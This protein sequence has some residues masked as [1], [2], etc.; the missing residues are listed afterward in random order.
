ML[1]RRRRGLEG[2]GRWR[3]RGG[4]RCGCRRGGFGLG[5]GT[6]WDGVPEGRWGFRCG[7]G[8]VRG[9]YFNDG[10]FALDRREWIGNGCRILSCVQDRKLRP[11]RCAAPMLSASPS[12]IACCCAECGV[13]PSTQMRSRELSLLV[14]HPRTTSLLKFPLWILGPR[15]IP[16][17]TTNTSSRQG[18]HPPRVH[19]SAFAVKW[20]G[21]YD[22]AMRGEPHR[23]ED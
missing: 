22:I 16:V 1:W 7:S 5:S 17:P 10:S 23:S 15:D 9:V 6:F 21:D 18:Q 8:V 14:K 3:G 13:D 2:V 12:N 20:E 19:A 4:A 11:P